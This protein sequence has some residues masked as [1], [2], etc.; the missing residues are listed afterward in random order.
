MKS[1]KTL[2]I[3]FIIFICLKNY[4][5]TNF[6]N[7]NAGFEVWIPKISGEGGITGKATFG[8][9][10]TDFDYK[11]KIWF[12][13][14]FLIGEQKNE[15]PI[16]SYNSLV[17]ECIIGKYYKRTN[18][19]IGFRYGYSKSPNEK[20]KSLYGPILFLGYESDKKKKKLGFYGNGR[21]LFIDLGDHTD[22]TYYQL[23][24]GLLYN[25]KKIITKIGYMYRKYY[26]RTNRLRGGGL[27]LNISIKL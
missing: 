2:C 12:K 24:G 18:I 13:G 5:L 21:W 25:M 20:A 8:G 4:A 16:Q 9:V 6:N 27:T 1:L 17:T 14:I 23:E 10:T 7:L 19:G 3:F 22:S 15:I 26:K 11:D